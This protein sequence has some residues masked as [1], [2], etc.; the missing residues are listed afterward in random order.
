[1]ARRPALVGALLS[2]LSC[3]LV[4]DVAEPLLV[5]LTV[6]LVEGELL[7]EIEPLLVDGEA[8]VDEVA[9]AVWPVELEL[10][11][12]EVADDIV[13]EVVVPCVLLPAAVLPELPVDDWAW[14]APAASASAAA[15]TVMLLERRF[16]RN[17]RFNG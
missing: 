16:I 5:L 8:E 11:A 3:E 12:S 13:P 15:M 4:V 1:L 17:S 10:A 9:P 6:E 2:V 7:V 14:A